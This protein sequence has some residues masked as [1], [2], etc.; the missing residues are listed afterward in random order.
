MIASEFEYFAPTEVGEALDLLHTKGDGARPLAG[1]MSLVPLMRVGMRHPAVVVSLH[2]VTGLDRVKDL[3]PALSIGAMCRHTAVARD[4]LVLRDAP[5][6]ARAAASIGDVQIRNRGTLGG[7]IAHADPAADYPS[8]LVALG[9]TM[10]VRS[11]GGERRVP[12]AE[13]F[14]DVM[15]TVL[16]ADELIVAV[17][18]PKHTGLGFAHERL[19]RVEGE[20]PIVLASLQLLPGGAGR[21]ALG[22]VGV[23]PVALELAQTSADEASLCALGRRAFD[24]AAGARGDSNGSR[25]YR[26]AMARVMSERALLA[27]CGGK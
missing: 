20:F 15:R 6:L 21:L 10:I 4:P 26:Q 3:G 12:A 16:E 22:G 13:F 2:Y 8:A 19:Q 17:E 5:L 25:E 23:K 7:S 18:V 1:G 14:V 11:A 24:A 27:A 9:A